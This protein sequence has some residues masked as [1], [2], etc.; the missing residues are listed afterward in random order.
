MNQ[1]PDTKPPR[2]AGK[3][4]RQDPPGAAAHA[5]HAAALTEADTRAILLIFLGRHHPGCHGD[6]RRAV[7]D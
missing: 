2:A 1:L 6:A 7:S 5:A 3:Q 4:R